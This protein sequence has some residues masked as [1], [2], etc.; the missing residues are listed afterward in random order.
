MNAMALTILLMIKNLYKMK[1][2]ITFIVI[3]QST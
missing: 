2:N 3:C 1:P